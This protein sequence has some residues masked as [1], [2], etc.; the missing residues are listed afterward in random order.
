MNSY[1]F[2]KL[3][4]N[5]WVLPDEIRGM[6]RT[7]EGHTHLFTD[8]H[9]IHVLLPPE[10]I[11]DLIDNAKRRAKAARDA[12]FEESIARQAAERSARARALP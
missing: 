11:L 12:E 5:E 10:E 3:G 2:V 6:S 1:D 9:T 7:S 8:R 4:D